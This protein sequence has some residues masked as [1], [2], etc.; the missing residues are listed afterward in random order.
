VVPSIIII[1]KSTW[2][3]DY[4]KQIPRKQSPLLVNHAERQTR[5]LVMM[6]LLLLL[7]KDLLEGY[8]TSLIMPP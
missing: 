2:K 1:K 6:V 4:H 5:L 8:C 7:L 3:K